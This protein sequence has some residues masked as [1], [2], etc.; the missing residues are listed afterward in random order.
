MR[1]FIIANQTQL[2]LIIHLNKMYVKED[3]IDTMM[4][5]L[6]TKISLRYCKFK[7]CDLR[8]GW[9]DDKEIINMSLTNWQ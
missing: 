4:Q 8:I 1:T 3:H 5:S 7:P 2:I 6:F 9:I